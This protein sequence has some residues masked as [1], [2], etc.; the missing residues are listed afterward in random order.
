MPLILQV[1]SID[2][3]SLPHSLLF[4]CTPPLMFALIQWIQGQHLSQGRMWSL[5][6]GV[7]GTFIV[8]SAS[9]LEGQANEVH[10]VGD[11]TAFLAAVSFVVYLSAGKHLR[12]SPWQFPL[13]SL[14]CILV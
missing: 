1:Y 9:R 6:T 13:Y 8:A 2:H 14:A 3:T 5:T 7:V 4:V 11:L 10:F 12:G